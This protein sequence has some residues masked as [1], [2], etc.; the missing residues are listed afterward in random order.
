MTDD[1]YILCVEKKGL[2]GSFFGK[3]VAL[4]FDERELCERHLQPSSRY[5]QREAVERNES[6]FQVI[7]YCIVQDENGYILTYSRRGSE[8]RLHG[9]KSCGL[10]G[11]VSRT[12]RGG[13]D[14]LIDSIHSGLAR[15]LDEECGIHSDTSFTFKGIIAES[16][17]PAGR[18]HL[19]MV[20]TT[21]IYRGQL[22][23]SDEVLH[24]EWMT[25]EKILKH[26]DD[27]ELW[28]ALALRLV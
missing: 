12:D 28:S 20:Y 13:G 23:F 6:L 14:S 9:L 2:P 16:E 3:R 5:E 1:E 15:E 10:G 27:F 18:V 22:V 19:G 11:H 7:P 8:K 24:H 25:I 17:T 4:P 21:A 26:I